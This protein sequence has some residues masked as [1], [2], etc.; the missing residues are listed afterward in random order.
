MGLDLGLVFTHPDFRRRGVAGLFLRWGNDFADE[1]G[2][3]ITLA[4]TETGLSTYQKYGF[5]PAERMELNL[6]GVEP[7]ERLEELKQI[8]LPI[9]VWPMIRPRN[10]HDRAGAGGNGG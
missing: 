9:V 5:I 7:S 6:N 10:S 8:L 1:N 2:W 3:E 4:A